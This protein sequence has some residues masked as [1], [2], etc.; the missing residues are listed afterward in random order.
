MLFLCY[1]YT[2]AP[3]VKGVEK[4]KNQTGKKIKIF[5]QKNALKNEKIKIFNKRIENILV[6]MIKKNVNSHENRKKIAENAM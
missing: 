6:K 2:I 1:S 5:S 3:D 4:Q